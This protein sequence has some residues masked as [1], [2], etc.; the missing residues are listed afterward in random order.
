ME[1][2]KMNADGS[3]QVNLT[4]DPGG[5]FVPAYSPDGKQIAFTSNRDGNY[6]VYKMSA[7][8]GNQTNLSNDPQSIDELPSWQPLP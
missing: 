4:K 2:Y 7:S 5:D 6:E 3:N 8:G 1:I